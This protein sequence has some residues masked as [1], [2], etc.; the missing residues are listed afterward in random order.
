MK[1][2]GPDDTLH[3]F[4]G[5]MGA[6]AV[7]T[8]Q[9]PKGAL[10]QNISWELLR[11][12]RLDG[13]VFHFSQRSTGSSAVVVSKLWEYGDPGNK[14]Q[15]TWNTE[16]ATR[17]I[18]LDH[19]IWD[20]IDGCDGNGSDSVVAIFT[21]RGSTKPGDEGYFAGNGTLKLTVRVESTA[22]RDC[23]LPHLLHT[24][25][26]T[27]LELSLLEL[28]PQLGDE[29]HFGLE[30]TSLEDNSLNDTHRPSMQTSF[31]DEYTPGAFTS[32]AVVPLS[33]A[34][35][36][37]LHSYVHWK[38]V[39]YR[40]SEKAVTLSIDVH[41]LNFTSAAHWWQFNVAT[42]WLAHNAANVSANALNLTFGS[43]G[44]GWY[45]KFHHT[46]WTMSVGFGEMPEDSV[47]LTVIAVT[48]VGLGV[49]A[50][51]A[52][53]TVGYLALYKPQPTL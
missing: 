9:T 15:A 33:N 40:D 37:A 50:I 52:L 26:S 43:E 42:A 34:S 53:V 28:L 30:L 45:N 51:V 22:G 25:N 4:W 48:S 12:H 47:S 44:D 11:D 35:L 31:D 5:T 23:Q 17:S 41:H 32:T 39:A 20:N 8:I 13:T 18:N 6:P 2:E 10:L 38:P 14:G 3:H 46:A 29:S 21:A 49:P 19:L 1:A 36:E 7:L 16:N 27:Q 24:S